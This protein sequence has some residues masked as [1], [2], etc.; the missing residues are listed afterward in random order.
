VLGPTDILI[1]IGVVAVVGPVG[2][3]ALDL[4]LRRLH[5]GTNPSKE[6]S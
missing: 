6:Q 5:R 3:I 1:A 2:A 4:L